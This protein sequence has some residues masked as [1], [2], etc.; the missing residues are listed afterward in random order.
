MGIGVLSRFSLSRQITV[1]ASGIAFV[2]LL[3]LAV[4]ISAYVRERSMVA[5]KQT[6]S[7]NI[8]MARDMVDL[9]YAIASKFTE[10]TYQIFASSYDGQ[11]A[12]DGQ[13]VDVAGVSTPVLTFDGKQVNGDV[14]LV[15]R[16][17]LD[18]GGVATVFARDGEDFVRV[19][20]SLK[21]Q[22]GSRAIATY[23][24]DKHPAHSR[25]LAG[26]EFQGSATLFGKPY[27]TRYVPQRDSSG[28]IVAVLFVGFDVQGVIDSLQKSIASIRIGDT[29]YIYVVFTDGPQKGSFFAHPQL[30]GRNL[31]DIV[32]DP[33]HPL[34]A[35]A[36]A[37][38]SQAIYP[39][40]DSNGNE[41]DKL[42]Y[43]VH[44]NSWGGLNV[45]GGTFLYE[46]EK[47]GDT[48]GRGIL[49]GGLVTAALLA[50]VIGLFVRFQLRPV[51][52]L[53][54]LLQ[55]VGNGDLSGFDDRDQEPEQ[56]Q[57][58]NEIVLIENEV[59]RTARQVRALVCDVQRSAVDVRE[60]AQ[61]LSQSAGV[62]SESA[63]VQSRATHMMAAA[64]EEIAV[65]INTVSQSADQFHVQTSK[66]RS[67]SDDGAKALSQTVQ[68]FSQIEQTV[69]GAAQQIETLG[70]NSESIS[71]AVSIIKSIADQTNL[72]ALN[73]AIEAAR[74]GEH[75]RG[76]AVVADEVRE[77]AK[78]TT[79]S[80]QE[81]S[82]MVGTIQ[83]GAQDAVSSMRE[84][85]M[86]VRNGAASVREAGTLMQ[87]IESSTGGV[88]AASDEINRALSEQAAA[89]SSLSSEVDNVRHLTEKMDSEAHTT[90]EAASRMNNIAG[91]L[92]SV[93]SRFRVS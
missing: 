55:R 49:I 42:V 66:T 57:V 70:S 35:I 31:N 28:N 22:D 6:V 47:D 20:S 16:F 14:A 62:L 77:L 76:F 40:Q 12:V 52:S 45:A 67:L 81:I 71:K 11:F 23:L 80:T 82:E 26:Q 89:S 58:A 75:G 2:G 93:V 44:T 13:R 21:K 73:A 10:R 19:T 54:Q 91:D 69:D 4:V 83:R 51:S 59:Q 79:S 72:L 60:T 78:R 8:G 63:S 33:D 48:V 39:W 50:L 68:R 29:G 34:L 64:M 88:V 37:G 36:D 92:L 61:H 27:I 3:V 85:T 24:G 90:T 65:S 25:L 7:A 1:V 56:S 43:F 46:L 9:S 18:S 87:S 86:R 41:K 74:A 15:D 32:K 84:T 38:D 30:V 53:L 5:A 17:T